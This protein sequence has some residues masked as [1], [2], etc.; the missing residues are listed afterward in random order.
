MKLYWLIYI[1]V[2]LTTFSSLES[3]DPEAYRKYNTIVQYDYYFRKYT[4]RFFG[5][6]FD[7]R[8]FK[9]QAI[10]ESGLKYDAESAAGAVGIM[11]ILPNTFDG[12]KQRNPEIRGKPIHVRWNI[13][14]GVY[15]NK[16]L[17]DLW[18]AER[19]FQ[20][21]I[22]FMFGSYNAGKGNILRAQKKASKRGLNP[23]LWRSITLTLKD[24]TGRRSR[25]TILYVNKIKLIK[26]VLH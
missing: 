12:L 26:E 4:K 19:P 17:W 16:S 15:Y 8:H 24:V 20:D 5:P 7:W 22:D 9:A 6:A 21:R 3:I 14:G 1:L 13:A 23:N 2:I 18:K 10:A 25:E 11:Q